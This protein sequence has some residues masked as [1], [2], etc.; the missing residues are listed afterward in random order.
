MS[1]CP[2]FA[3][4]FLPPFGR[5]KEAH[6]ATTSHKSMKIQYGPRVVQY[7]WSSHIGNCSKC[8]LMVLSSGPLTKTRVDPD[9]VLKSSILRRSRPNVGSIHLHRGSPGED[10]LLNT[11]FGPRARLSGPTSTASPTRT[12]QK[13]VRNW[14]GRKPGQ[15]GAGVCPA[16][17]KRSASMALVSGA[18]PQN[19]V[20]NLARTS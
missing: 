19:S 5:Q 8:R 4:L 1:P 6:N 3:R 14:P 11:T 7:R 15:S 12:D 13:L 20:E 17:T 18:R 9:R 16:H 10:G 2:W